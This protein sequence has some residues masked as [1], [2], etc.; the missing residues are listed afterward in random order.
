MWQEIAT[1]EIIRRVVDCGVSKSELARLLGVDRKTIYRWLKGENKPTKVPL[2]KLEK[3]FDLLED[4]LTDSYFSRNHGG[5]P[6]NFFSFKVTQVPAEIIKSHDG[7]PISQRELRMR[8]MGVKATLSKGESRVLRGS[9]AKL[10]WFAGIFNITYKVLLDD[11]ALLIRE[12]L[13]DHK[14]K[15]KYVAEL[16]LAALRVASARIAYKLDDVKLKMLFED[17]L[18]DEAM[19][20]HFIAELAKQFL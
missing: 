7:K 15:R 10:T 18:V 17:E 19:Y 3:L 2:Y 11:S 20:R 5:P 6:S 8:L 4:R 12:Y 13:K 1:S 14:V 16:A 9:L